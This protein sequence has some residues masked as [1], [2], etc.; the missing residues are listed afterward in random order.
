M[1]NVLITGSEGNIGK[2]LVPRLSRD[3][4]LTL[5][6]LKG[7]PK[8]DLKSYKNILEVMD[9]HAVVHLAWNSDTENFTNEH[10]DPDNALMA[11]NVYRAALEMKV[12]RVIMASSV[13]AD[14]YRGQQEVLISPERTPIPTSVYGADKVFIESLGRL[15]ASKGLE[16]V[17]IRFGAVG[18]SPTDEEGRMLWLS[19]NDCASLI[20]TLIDAPT[21]PGNFSLIYGIS[22]NIGK[23]HNTVNPFGWEPQEG[24][25]G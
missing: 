12:P 13:H 11:H 5:R 23:V 21:V 2:L 22:N 20:K 8:H 6:D 1:K 24:F 18:E 19:P 14:N 25:R 10:I 3:Y 9:Q 16:V 15:Y 4:A 17:C 7:G